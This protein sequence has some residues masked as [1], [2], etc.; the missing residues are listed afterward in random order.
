MSIRVMS[1][2][3][4]HSAHCGSELLMLLAIADFADDE[5]R[6]YPAVPTLAA[7]CRMSARN[8][9]MLL[10]K[11]RESGELEIRI[12]AGP[13]GTNMY[14]I[15]LTAPLKPASSLTPEAHFTPEAAFTLKPASPTP[16]AGF[17]IPLKPASDEPSLNHQEP[18]KKRERLSPPVAAS[19]L[20]ID[21]EPDLFADW[22]Q[23]R[24]AKRVGPVTETVVKLLR[25]EAAKAGKT[26]QQALETCCMRGW[27]SFNAEWAGASSTA[28]PAVLAADDVFTGKS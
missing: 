8:A 23:V 21:V 11:L 12:G 28:K 27:A 22:E 3:W 18:K 14:R 1:R 6:A 5:G 20:L 4:D 25:S 16:E 19:S 17:P 2:A 7:K 24:K 9:N 26:V 15:R 10:T 13:R